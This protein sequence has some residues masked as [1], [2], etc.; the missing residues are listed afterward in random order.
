MSHD[1]KKNAVNH[2][3]AVIEGLV[4]LKKTLST[5]FKDK[6]G[7]VFITNMKAV[8]SESD[9]CM[10]VDPSR[11]E[12]IS[13]IGETKSKLRWV[14]STGQVYK[15]GQLQPPHYME[16][17]LKIFTG[18]LSDVESNKAVMLQNKK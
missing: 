7:T 15:N 9:Y 4:G 8:E 13:G 1:I 16:V 10:M 12:L 5:F 18:V 11:M 14:V 6:P 3:A 2:K 17:V